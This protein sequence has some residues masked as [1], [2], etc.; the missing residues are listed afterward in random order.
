MIVYLIQETKNK[1][2]QQFPVLEFKTKVNSAKIFLYYPPTK[3]KYAD[4]FLPLVN[5]IFVLNES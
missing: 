3:L 2:Q 1:A 4:N 5:K